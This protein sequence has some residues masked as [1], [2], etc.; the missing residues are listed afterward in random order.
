MSRAPSI[1]EIHAKHA[2]YQAGFGAATKT[3]TPP[4]P[5]TALRFPGSAA[6]DDLHGEI[7]RRSSSPD[8]A[9]SILRFI[10]E[11]PEFRALK[12]GKDRRQFLSRKM[13]EIRE[14]MD[15]IQPK[16]DRLDYLKRARD[17]ITEMFAWAD[18]PLV[19]QKP[20]GVAFRAMR[21]AI[22]NGEGL[23]FGKSIDDVV[24]AKDYEKEVFCEAEI[25]L[26]EHDWAAAFASTDLANSEVRL[27]YDVCAFEFQISE[28]RVIAIATQLE[29]S[30]FFTPIVSTS[31]GW[32]IPDYALPVH[33]GFEDQ[34]IPSNYDKYLDVLG[35]LNRQ[36]RAICIALDAEVAKSDVVREPYTGRVGNNYHPAPKP[37][38]V[39]S[40]ARRQSHALPSG[41][42]TGRRVRLHFRRGHWRH[43][44]THKTWINWMLVGDPELGFIEKHY[45]L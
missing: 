21:K 20:D 15:A 16:R 7:L 9:E 14:Q 13:H 19:L 39:V 33:L 32:I 3:L 29:T 24:P 42:E 10:A 40:L 17:G 41:H 45:K 44:A 34:T 31:C 28:R 23:Y 12:T 11:N 1:L 35:L 22:R 30:V 2:G 25:M 18:A 27:P 5:D 26:V 4:K 8:D 38:R 37:Y 43:F 36:V 6:A